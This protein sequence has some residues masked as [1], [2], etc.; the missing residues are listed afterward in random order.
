VNKDE[1]E[2]WNQ[3]LEY[4]IRTCYPTPARNKSK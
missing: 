3:L 4:E 2:E 1:P